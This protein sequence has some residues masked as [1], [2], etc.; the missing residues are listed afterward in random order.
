MGNLKY[1]IFRVYNYKGGELST[2]LNLTKDKFIC[3]IIAYFIDYDEIEFNRQIP[4]VLKL[5]N[6]ILGNI[7]ELSNCA[8]S[9]DDTIVAKFYCTSTESMMLESIILEKFVKDNILDIVNQYC[10][11]YE[12]EL[13]EDDIKL[14]NKKD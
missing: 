8:G 3:S 12:Y 14:L 1:H 5:S 10:K 13:T 2:A 6:D 11:Y 9:G 7:N 4:D